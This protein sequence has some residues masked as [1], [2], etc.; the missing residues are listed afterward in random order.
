V[1]ST[2]PKD[3]KRPKS[4]RKK[5]TINSAAD[6]ERPPQSLCGKENM[7]TTNRK[8]EKSKN[9]CNY[10]ANNKNFMA[11]QGQPPSAKTKALKSHG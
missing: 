5:I 3:I 8:T 4:V 11:K 1:G 2:R 9:F 10:S 7:Q 6:D